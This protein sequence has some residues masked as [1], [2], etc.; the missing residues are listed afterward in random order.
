MA[1][2]KASLK[3]RGVDILFGGQA[4]EQAEQPAAPPA[5]VKAGPEPATP[6]GLAEV[7]PAVSGEAGRA[8]AMPNPFAEPA[9]SPSVSVARLAPETAA[10]GFNPF[11][12]PAPAPLA[13][14]AL[15]V[16]EAAAA[17]PNPFAEPAPSPSVSAAGP[18]LETA[19]AGFNPF[20]EP[21][22]APPS[23]GEP[24]MIRPY[25][26]PPPTAT[27]EV[28]NLLS[29][30]ALSGQPTA[31]ISVSLPAEQTPWLADEPPA[32]ADAV[33]PE[34]PSAAGA[35]SIV[36]PTDPTLFKPARFGGIA[37]SLE[38][39]SGAGEYE[40]AT[41]VT[42]TG[43]KAATVA[44]PKQEAS[45]EEVQQR[46]G[47]E[48]IKA[49]S[50][51]IDDLYAQLAGGAIANEDI[52]GQA[53]VN[54]RTARDMELEDPRQFDQAEYLVNL[55]HY[56]I[57]RS[58][59]IQKVRRWSYSWGVPVMLYGA[60]WLVAFGAGFA[61]SALGLIGKWLTDFGLGKELVDTSS[62]LFLSV[63][64]GGLGGVLGLLYSLVRH[65]SV[66]QDFDRQ[67]LLWYFVQ[68]LLGILMGTI[69]HLFVVAGLF[70]AFNATG[71]IAQA[72]GA[73]GAL[74]A[75]FRQNYVYAWLESLLKRIGERAE[76][77]ETEAPPPTPQP[78]AAAAP[79]LA[80]EAQASP[81]GVG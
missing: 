80:S 16:V 81:P 60:L 14:A 34:T 53:L 30:E 22:P 25:A 65:A 49:L 48:H 79:A 46:I 29:H 11:A 12:E 21:A 8:A 69:V 63:M 42:Q 1:K 74:A 75:A 33:A 20:A 17:M 35:T 9:P 2:K 4:G 31:P 13:P 10:A 50:K 78:E 45:L 6:T 51:R 32:I 76:K 43:M 70:Q 26:E 24:G 73:L 56:H 59:S 28:E 47:L 77:P 19:A 37:M 44:A 71:P 61:L 7:A 55:V 67:F 23:P 38:V 72:I 52:A 40:P 66:Q 68:P 58:T 39:M 27:A 15:P 36:V 3:G 57:S 41:G 62:A 5:V 54:L 18:T 64:A